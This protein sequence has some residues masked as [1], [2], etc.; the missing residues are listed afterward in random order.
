MEEK[1][2]LVELVE[3]LEKAKRYTQFCLDNE[4]GTADMKDLEYWAKRV[5]ELRKQVKEML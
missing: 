2:K 5:V 4:S 1:S 3:E